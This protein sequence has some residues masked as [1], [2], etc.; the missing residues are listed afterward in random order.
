MLESPQN[1]E[2]S[3]MESLAIDVSKFNSF[4]WSCLT[5]IDFRIIAQAFAHMHYFVIQEHS[6]SISQLCCGAE[7]IQ[8]KL[9]KDFMLYIQNLMVHKCES[10][11]SM[12]NFH[13]PLGLVIAFTLFYLEEKLIF[14]CS[15][16]VFEVY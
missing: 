5:D 7:R 1:L 11:P 13:K 16:N 14:V 12:P 6:F 3:L 15:H 8:E 9:D 4:A 10:I 2:Q